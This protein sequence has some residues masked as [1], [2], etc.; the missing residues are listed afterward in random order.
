MSTVSFKFI[1]II[2][3]TQKMSFFAGRCELSHWGCEL[4]N[5]A[6]KAAGS[7]V[8][9]NK[10]QGNKGV[11][12][13]IRIAICDDMPVFSQ[14]VNAL[15]QKWKNKPEEL[16][17]DLFSDADSLISAHGEKPYDILF[18]DVV[19]PLLGGIEAAEEIRQQD[20]SVRIVFLTASAE[21]AIDSYRVKASNYLLKPVDPAL[22][23]RCLDDLAQE[24][25]QDTKAIHIRSRHGIHRVELN[26]IEYVEASNK[27]VIFSLSDG[28]VILSPDPL[29]T[30][31]DHLLVSDGFYKCSRSYIVNI[32]RIDTYTT[33]EI[34]MRSG[35][36]IPIAR[37]HQKDF[38]STYFALLFGKAGD[39]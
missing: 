31:Q 9:L 37:S 13:V 20:K 3:L 14:Q 27:D 30:F 11:S 38:E 26:R 21:F 10:T 17:V 32:Y 33:K 23:Y 2:I 15:I 8:I 18:L 12:A 39:L 24:I 19:M 22:L 29:Y 36:R 28:Q 35:C 6:L 25:L 4:Q 1:P 34:R 7:F 16:S 5:S